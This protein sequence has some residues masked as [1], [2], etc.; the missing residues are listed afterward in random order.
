MYVFSD[1][2]FLK[3]YP[4]IEESDDLLQW[5][6]ETRAVIVPEKCSYRLKPTNLELK[7]IKA[8]EC[9]WESLEATSGKLKK[10]P[11]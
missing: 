4:I 6:L 11:C 8:I 1:P 9:K 10:N 2:A 3:R 5:K 7:L